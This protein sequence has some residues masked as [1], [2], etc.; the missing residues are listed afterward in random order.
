VGGDPGDAY[1]AAA[2]L[3]HQEDIEAAEE[4][5]VEVGEVDREDCVGQRCEEIVA[6]SV[7]TAAERDRSRRP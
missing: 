1:A 7:R 5:G 6:R 2:V 4:D 3:D